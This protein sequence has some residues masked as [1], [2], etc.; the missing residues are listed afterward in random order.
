MS[1]GW[2]RASYFAQFKSSLLSIGNNQLE[3]NQLTTEKQRESRRTAAQ[4]DYRQSMHNVSRFILKLFLASSPAEA[5]DHPASLCVCEHSF[6]TRR[7]RARRSVGGEGVDS[8]TGDFANLSMSSGFS[9]FRMLASAADAS[10]SASSNNSASTTPNILSPP[11]TP[12]S[13]KILT[14]EELKS[15]KDKRNKARQD[16][17]DLDKKYRSALDAFCDE[18][19]SI[20]IWSHSLRNACRLAS[21]R[22]G[23]YAGRNLNCQINHCEKRETL[24]SIDALSIPCTEVHPLIAC[25]NSPSEN[26]RTTADF[27][28]WLEEPHRPKSSY[29]SLA[30]SLII[31]N[32]PRPKMACGMYWWHKLHLVTLKHLEK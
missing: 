7:R 11:S 23:E 18:L 31:F 20:V 21:G 6:K 3:N 28:S 1:Q 24:V 10:T 32:L 29:A 19:A 22:R 9:G 16:F 17:L 13:N 5:T 15:L 27:C 14:I 4:I 30:P 8:L 12:N 2:A 26:A 25:I